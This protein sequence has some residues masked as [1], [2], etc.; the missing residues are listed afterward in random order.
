MNTTT[1]ADS[2]VTPPRLATGRAAVARLFALAVAGLTLCFTSLFAEVIDDFEEKWRISWPDKNYLRKDLIN[3]ELKISGQL[4]ASGDS[5]SVDSP[6]YWLY[7]PPP[8]DL[9]GRTLEVRIDLVSASADDVFLMLG[10]GSPSGEYHLSIDQDEVSLAK[11][12]Y[13]LGVASLF[14]V[15]APVTNRNVTV[16]LAVTQMA[17]SVQL[18]TRVVDKGTGTILFEKRF[19]DGP[20]VDVQVPTPPPKGLTSLVPDSGAPIVGFDSAWIGVWQWVARPPRPPL[21]VVVDN[22]EYDVYDSPALSVSTSGQA[23]VFSWPVSTTA[24]ELESAP[25]LSPEAVWE[26]IPTTPIVNG[27]RQTLTLDA[28]TTAQFFRLKKS[29]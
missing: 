10:V 8:S 28:T 6:I 7:S 14:W 17:D 23:L 19:V 12:Q 29:P 22:L 25:S 9:E 5:V 27:D 2:R 3:G 20:G 1:L 15:T 13:P 24:F 4:P 26:T 16:V 11:Q 21:E 18:T